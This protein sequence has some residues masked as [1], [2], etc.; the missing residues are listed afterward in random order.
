MS[1]H[2]GMPLL[3][4]QAMSSLYA[5]LGKGELKRWVLWAILKMPIRRP[6]ASG[7][8]GLPGAICINTDT[9]AASSVRR[10][11]L[12]DEDLFG[13]IELEVI[14]S[15][16]RRVT[17]RPICERE[18]RPFLF[19]V[20]ERV[21]R[22]RARKRARDLLTHVL[23]RSGMEDGQATGNIDALPDGSLESDGMRARLG[24]AL[25]RLTP[26]ERLLVEAMVTESYDEAAER[27]GINA[28]TVRNRACELRGRL[29]AELLD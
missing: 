5:L 26:E 12:Q 11:L 2:D 21:A 23:P 9:P 18:I 20:T 6:D 15:F 3:A 1:D 29:R 13:Q 24:A 14:T 10:A 22:R 4:E 19:V 16:H 27:L 8:P 17:A 7:A 25:R 28:K